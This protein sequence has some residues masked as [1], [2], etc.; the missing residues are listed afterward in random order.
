LGKLLARFRMNEKRRV[1]RAQNDI[2]VTQPRSARL[3]RAPRYGLA[4]PNRVALL[5]VLGI[6]MQLNNMITFIHRSI[7]LP[8]VKK[9]TR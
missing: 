2:L 9:G 4:P 5:L 3:T 7:S 1:L 8:S 6:A